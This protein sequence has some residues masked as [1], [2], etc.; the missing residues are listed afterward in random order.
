MRAVRCN[1]KQVEIVE[2]P[3]PEGPGVRVK[4]RSAGI[5]GSDLHWLNNPAEL[6]VTLGHEMGGVTEDGRCVAVEPLQPCGS[7]DCCLRGDYNLCDQGAIASMGVALDG[8]MADEV[9][10]PER[11]LIPLPSGV[12]VEDSCLIE[13]LAVGVRGLRLAGL[14]GTQRVAIVGGGT[15]GLC[16]AA[17]CV[18]S[19][20]ETT[21]IAR[22]DR[23]K[24]AVIAL[25][26]TLEPNGQ[27]DLVVEAAGTPEALAQAVQLCRPGGTLLILALYWDGFVFPGNAGFEVILKELR[28]IPSITYGQHGAIRDVDTAAAL[29]GRLP[30]LVDILVTHRYPLDAAAEAFAT[31]ADRS[32]A[33]KVVLEP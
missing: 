27:Y 13:P 26:A 4:I 3:R 2:V 5:C 10:V 12:R 33:I 25:G 31:A 22:H 19:G 16:A 20:A 11:C 28:M 9:L 7:C 29:L 15:I 17:P 32:K 23:Q 8:G 1:N 6:A 24:E 18:F 30:D 21:V 14:T